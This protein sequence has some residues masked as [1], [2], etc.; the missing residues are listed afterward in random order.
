MILGKILPYNKIT[1]KISDSV[2]VADGA[3]VIGDVEIGKQS[4]VWYNC[5][6]RG[7]V[8]YIRIGEFTNIQD[9]SMLHVTNKLFPLKIGNRVTIGH[10]VKLHGCT[11]EDLALIGIGAVVLDGAVIKSNS[12]VAAGSVVK[13][14]FVVPEKVLVAGVPAKIVRQLTQD[15]IDD[16]YA[17]SERYVEYTKSTLESLK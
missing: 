17:S 12:I 3:I 16:L 7:D 13:P 10:S 2:F 15:E 5:V 4:S 9:L 14:G 1:P 6:I 8:N 11:I